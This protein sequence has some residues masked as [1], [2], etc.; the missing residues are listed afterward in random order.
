VKLA[1]A[2]AVAACLL[3][4]AGLWIG[5]AAIGP[6]SHGREIALDERRIDDLKDISSRLRTRYRDLGSFPATLPSNWA[7][8]PV[9]KLPYEYTR[10]D[11]LHFALC[12]V[13]YAPSDTED[14]RGTSFWS[15]GAGKKCYA[16]DKSS[17]PVL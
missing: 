10:A 4:A 6:P 5:F 14:S 2:I 15:H 16:F 17:E 8:D 12:A 13:F 7:T 9:T 11:Q 1:P 3:V